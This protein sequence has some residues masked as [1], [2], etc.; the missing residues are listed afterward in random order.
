VKLIGGMTDTTRQEAIDRFQTDS[1]VNVMIS[2][3]SAG[4]IG[5]NL[6]AASYMLYFSKSF[7][8]EADI[9]SEARAHRGGSEIHDK[10]T[11]IDL[12]SPG[13]VD[14]VITL[15]LWN[16]VDVSESILKMRE[17]FL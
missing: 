5:V 2:N 3:Q 9:Q 10:I 12:V 14:E 6:T 1:G 16:K 13:S 15:A 7:S 17:K 11:R 4:G 8:L